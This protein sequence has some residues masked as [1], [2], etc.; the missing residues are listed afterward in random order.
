MAQNVKQYGL[1]FMLLLAIPTLA[2]GL[3]EA[4]P[5]AA[6]PTPTGTPSPTA[7]S[8]P[9]VSFVDRD[10]SVLGLAFRYPDSW[11]IEI[12]ESSVVVASDV[13]LL[14]A[15]EFDRE[16]A[17]ALIV[18]GGADTFAGDTLEDSLNAAIQQFD[19]TENNRVVE[20]PRQTTIGGQEAVTATIE[21]SNL[22]GSQTLIVLVTLLRNQDRMA[23][24]AGVTLLSIIEQ[25]RETLDTVAQSVV[26]RQLETTGESQSQGVLRYGDAVDGQIESGR[27]AS[28]TFIGVEGERIDLTVRPLQDDLDVSVDIQNAQGVSILPSAPVDDSFGVETIRGLVLPASAEYTVLVSGFAQASGT[29]EVAIGEAGALTSAQSIAAGETLNGTL[30]QDE[31]DDYLF[32]SEQQEAVTIVVNPVGDLDVVLEVLDGEGAVIYQEDSSYGQEQLSFTPQPAGSYI[33]RVRGFAG[34]SGDYAITVQAGGVG[35]TGTTFVTTGTLDPGDAEGH[36]FPFSA[37]QGEVVQAIVIPDG[38]FDVV[39]EVWNDD[40]DEMEESIDASFGREQV[41]FTARQTGNYYFKVLGFEGQ[42]GS[43]TITLSGPPTVI[44]ELAAGDQVTGDLGQNSFIDYYIRLETNDEI[45]IDVQPDGDTDIVAEVLDLDENV[46]SSADEGFA[47]EVEQL[48]FSAPTSS[49]EAGLYILRIRNFS[50][51]AGGTFSLNLE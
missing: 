33:L 5:T 49:S 40:I 9:Q 24:I 37:D 23:F 25:Y 20:G 39:V 3:A 21:G 47:G 45:S 51:E 6:P 31:Q 2:C 29:F 10:V 44:F 11:E 26:L 41:N 36:D 4:T 50:D 38:D 16:G 30:G 34:A 28:W 48:A 17:G 7:T 32:S 19:F 15:Q 22:D 8:E 14:S 18:V 12:D 35:S 13:E 42:G 46:L 1:L 27:S 43:F